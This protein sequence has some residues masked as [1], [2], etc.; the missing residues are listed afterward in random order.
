MP[1]LSPEP[2]LFPAGLFEARAEI[3]TADRSWLVLHTKARQEKCLARQL[4]EGQVPFYLPLLGRRTRIR[5]RAVMSYNPLFGG[6]V[7]LLADER[8]RVAALATHRVVQALK[9]TD[10]QQ[11]WEDLAQ[12]RR[13]I[14]SGAPITPEDRLE[15]GMEV[16]I[17]SGP[18]AGLRG[19]ILRTA[20]GRRF[21]V[22]V[23][24]IQRGASL[25]VDDSVLACVRD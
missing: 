3:Q 18:L 11:L 7:F 24:F 25:E 12:V 15:P 16:E 1:I 10:Q 17:K 8:E 19:T 9:V 22:Q 4:Y 23:N 2:D 20:T 21:V 5:G 13:L 14:E 6:Y